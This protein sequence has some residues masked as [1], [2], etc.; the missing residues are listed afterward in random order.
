METFVIV[1][2][3]GVACAITLF[4]LSMSKQRFEEKVEGGEG[5][6]NLELDTSVKKELEKLSISSSKSDQLTKNLTVLVDKEVHKK[7]AFISQE[8]GKQYAQALDEKDKKLKHVE[9][10]FTMVNQKLE[11]VNKNYKK[12]QQEKKQ[13]EAVVR[14]VADG[15]IVVNEKGETLL[16]NPAAEKL[17]GVKKEDLTGKS[18]LSAA[19]EERLIT[20][21]TAVSGTVEEEKE[22]TVNSNDQTRRVLRSSTAV[23]ENEAGQT[24]GM[25]SVLTDVTKQKEL[26][27]MKNKFISNVTHELRTPLAAI[28]ESVN[29]FLDGMIGATTEEQKKVLAI[30]KRNIQRL[31]RLIDNVL[32]ISKLEAGKL[33]LKPSSFSLEEFVH[34]NVKAFDAWASSKVITLESKLPPDKMELE[35]DRDRMSQVLTNLI[36]NALKFTPQGGKITAEVEATI[37]SESNPVP[38]VQFSVSDTGCGI[39][40]K[41]KAKIFGKFAQGSLK[42]VDKISGTGLGLSISKEVVEL[43]GGR[44][45]FESEENVGSKFIFIIPQRLPKNE[46]EQEGERTP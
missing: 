24:M 36:G 18:I 16:I 33:E 43:H 4:L 29:L 2:V 23:I 28:K 5:S 10:K 32:D 30:A 19:K 44:I 6:E 3:V 39:P 35:V 7:A 37:L 15:L 27:E 14:S 22:I 46:S 45:W 8:V 42:P 9:E 38:A 12:V 13:T 31:G 34:E 41:D 20:L 21:A 26:E 11:V 1:L 40:E 17:L 25:V